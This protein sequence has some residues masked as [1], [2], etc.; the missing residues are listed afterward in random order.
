MKRIWQDK[1]WHE[2]EGVF[3]LEERSHS[4]DWSWCENRW[5]LLKDG[6][7]TERRFSNRLYSAKMMTS[8]L[9]QTDFS[10]TEVYGS[11]AGTPYDETAK[12]LVVVARK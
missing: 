10:R 6:I 8:L 2:N 12:R 11:L 5:I 9:L 7:K 4:D 1:D 3:L